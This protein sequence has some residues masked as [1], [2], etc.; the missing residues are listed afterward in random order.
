MLRFCPCLLF[1]LSKVQPVVDTPSRIDV[2]RHCSLNAFLQVVSLIHSF[3]ST[4]DQGG[5]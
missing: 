4:V 1:P 5:K 2:T 3:T